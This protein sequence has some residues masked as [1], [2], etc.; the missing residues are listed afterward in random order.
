M[1]A[2]NVTSGK[3]TLASPQKCRLS[4]YFTPS[5]EYGTRKHVVVTA[6][7][8]RQEILDPDD[9]SEVTYEIW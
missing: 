5:C 3:I 9:F 4:V 1:H 6:Y 7:V 2:P 8:P